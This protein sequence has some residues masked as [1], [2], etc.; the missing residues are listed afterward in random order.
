MFGT[1][2]QQMATVGVRASKPSQGLRYVH[3][4][5]LI[6]APQLH[7][8][9]PRWLCVSG[10]LYANTLVDIRL[11]YRAIGTWKVSLFWATAAF[12]ETP[13]P[14]EALC[15]KGSHILGSPFTLAVWAGPPSAQT[16]Q[17][18]SFPLGLLAGETFLVNLWA[19]D[20]F[21]NSI[22]GISSQLALRMYPPAQYNARSM[23]PAV[24]DAPPQPLY[25]P[26]VNASSSIQVGYTASFLATT[27]IGTHSMFA[28]LALV[29]GLSATYFSSTDLSGPQSSR[30]D[31]VVN[32]VRTAT[33]SPAASIPLGSAFGV[34]WSGLIWPQY[35]QTYTMT[36]L[37]QNSGERARL[38]VDNSLV[39]DQWTSLASFS[40]SATIAFS[41]ANGYYD[42]LLE[43]KQL[44]SSSLCGAGLY[45]A[46]N[47]VAYGLVPSSS[48]AEAHDIPGTPKSLAVISGPAFAGTS[49]ISGSCLSLA[50][51]GAACQFTVQFQD[52]YGIGTRMQRTLEAF[53]FDVPTGLSESIST[54]NCLGSQACS[55]SFSPKSQGSSLLSAF[56]RSS[57]SGPRAAHLKGSPAAVPVVVGR[58]LAWDMYIFGS[59]LSSFTAGW[60]PRLI[61]LISPPSKA[62]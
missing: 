33:S 55:L 58:T 18:T 24:R 8:A 28:S 37:L 14:M 49:T 61:F 32:L 2:G 46:G 40:T 29:G 30:H 11:S 3:V 36:V 4:P 16:L 53:A 57:T 44:S 26:S 1:I 38:W 52:Q 54:A 51:S 13:V 6:K 5:A 23:I 15:Y 7:A 27:K 62:H 22:Q 25:A 19:G 34:R 31:N 39:I 21:N 50:T 48:L 60:H 47:N 59:G 45:W 9:K 41:V 10:Q 43:Y 12:P 35:A 56:F 42:I 17:V 20:S